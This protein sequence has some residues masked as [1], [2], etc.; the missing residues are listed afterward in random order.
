MTKTERVIAD[1]RR[2]NLAS[3]LY[4]AI[5]NQD[6]SATLDAVELLEEFI[7]EVVSERVRAELIRRNHEN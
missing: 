1:Q 3:Q 6:H 7:E 4:D 2:L 5:S